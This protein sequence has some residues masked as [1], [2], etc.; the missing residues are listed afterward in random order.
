VG[1]LTNRGYELDLDT[2]PVRQLCDTDR[3]PCVFTGSAQGFDHDLRSGIEDLALFGEMGRRCHK[4]GDLQYSVE[5]VTEAVTYQVDRC[6]R[7]QP[8]CG[9]GSFQVDGVANKT[10]MDE[11]TAHPRKLTTQ[12]RDPVV[13]DDWR[14]IRAWCVGHFSQ[15]SRFEGC[16]EGGDLLNE[17]LRLFL[18]NVVA[19][20]GDHTPTYVAPQR[21]H[22]VIQVGCTSDVAA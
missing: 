1:L 11:F 18:G 16:D 20:I 3:A 17:E 5:A 12:V 15:F 6:L 2:G 19:T 9:T 10:A 13:F 7:G 4:P 14:Y 22:P 21:F 8:C